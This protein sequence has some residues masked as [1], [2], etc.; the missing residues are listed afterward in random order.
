MP[1]PNS[2]PVAPGQQTQASQYNNL[3]KD[4][5]YLGAETANSV[6]LGTFLSS[7]AFNVRVNYLAPNKLR[8]PYD[9]QNPASL[10]INGN[11]LVAQANIDLPANEFSGGAAV[12]YIF[13]NRA[14]AVS[15]FSLSVNTS[16]VP[17]PTQRLIGEVFWNGT[18]LAPQSIRSYLSGG[19]VRQPAYD[20]GWF[21]VTYNTTYNKA[22]GLGQLPREVATYWSSVAD[23]SNTVGPA[24]PFLNN[25]GPVS[26][27]YWDKVNIYCKTG[28]SSSYGVLNSMQGKSGSGYFRVLAWV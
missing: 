25:V 21:A 14:D 18:N 6:S 5:V 24:L 12:W 17:N 26:P 28:E 20:S 3:R 4:A 2:S 11:M 23:E 7:L 1:Y 22:H 27:C 8:V 13:A 16:P 9:S 19:D 15:S 10:V